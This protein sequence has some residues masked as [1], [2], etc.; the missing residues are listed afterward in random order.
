[1]FP[2]SLNCIAFTLYNG[3]RLA[4]TLVSHAKALGFRGEVRHISVSRSDF[5]LLLSAAA[6]ES[7]GQPLASFARW[8]TEQVPVY[9]HVAEAEVGAACVVVTSKLSNPRT[10]DRDLLDLYRLGK[11]SVRVTSGLQLELERAA[12]AAEEEER[13]SRH[14]LGKESSSSAQE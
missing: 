7:S 8:M 10:S 14:S 13:S 1:M 3:S 4:T 6:G 12:K 5:K 2:S 11:L 9:R